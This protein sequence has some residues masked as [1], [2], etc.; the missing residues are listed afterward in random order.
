MS[1]DYILKPL[2]SENLEQI[3]NLSSTGN[4]LKD[5]IKTE[6]LLDIGLEYGV[7]YYFD[8]VV[9]GFTEDIK[10]D[11]GNIM[12]ARFF[13]KQDEIRVFND[14]GTY[15]GTIFHQ[16]EGENPFVEE[17]YLLYPRGQNKM[18]HPTRLEV[19]KYIRYDQDNQAYIS[20]IK[21]V[22]FTF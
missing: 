10:I 15:T 14:E 7:I 12:E 3:Y 8:S 4:Q 11:F 2:T 9:A 1:D 5:I 13:N 21:P 19:C 18:D 16:L 6:V 22:K 17:S 20:Y